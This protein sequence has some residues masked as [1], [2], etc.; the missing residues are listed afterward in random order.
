MVLDF[1]KAYT[2]PLVGEIMAMGTQPY[3]VFMASA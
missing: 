3:G 2:L 1:R